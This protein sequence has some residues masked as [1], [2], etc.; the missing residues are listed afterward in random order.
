M[1]RLPHA[2]LSDYDNLSHILMTWSNDN[3][4]L[5]VSIAILFRVAWHR[6]IFPTE[7]CDQEPLILRPTYMVRN[8][9]HILGE[10]T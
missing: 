6:P 7:S 2:P 9:F 1:G 8:M 10:S 4:L 3:T 5:N